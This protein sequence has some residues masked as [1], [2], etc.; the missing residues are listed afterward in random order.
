MSVAVG[1]RWISRKA[2]DPLRDVAHAGV[3]KASG[4]RSQPAEA[5]PQGVTEVGS[6]RGRGTEGPQGP[7]GN[8][9][10]VTGTRGARKG[11]PGTGN[12]GWSKKASRGAGRFRSS[13]NAS[14]EVTRLHAGTGPPRIGH[15]DG[16]SRCRKVPVSDAERTRAARSRGANG[17]FESPGMLPRGV[18]EVLPLGYPGR[19]RVWALVSYGSCGYVVAAASTGGGGAPDPCA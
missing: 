10:R 11:R 3:T 15:R 7:A 5:A 14:E 6:G 19:F 18:R 8:R 4:C 1:S 2:L 9:L 17:G 16:T 12:S 13:V